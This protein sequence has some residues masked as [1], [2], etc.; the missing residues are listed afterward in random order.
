MPFKTKE[1]KAAYDLIYREEN[2]TKRNQ[3]VA[4]WKLNNPSYSLWLSCRYRA[5]RKGLDF[6]IE[7]EDVIVPAL[8]P[9]LGIPMKIGGD[10]SDSPSIDRI[11]SKKG[12]V[13][14]NII[15]ISH[16]ANRIKTDATWEELLKI[17]NWLKDQTT[18]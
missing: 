16:R 2:R 12:Y 1:E 10:K 17:A 7:V 6:T 5:A 9:V 11:D 14:G 8:C 18:L 3:Q 13:K 4:Q 15:V